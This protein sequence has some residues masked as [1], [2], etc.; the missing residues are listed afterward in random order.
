MTSG[1]RK[2]P[3]RGRSREVLIAVAADLFAR[4]P[5]DEIY[6]S[7]IAREAGV[8]NGLLSYHFNGKRGLYLAVLAEALEEINALLLPR[9]GEITKEQRLRGMVR[10]QIVYRR[11]HAHTML[12]L[13]RAGGQDPEVDEL[14]ERGRRAGT[15]CFLDLLDV[16]VEPT[17]TL[18]VAVRG[19]M[20]LLDEATRDW[21]VHDA[22]MGIGDLEE[23]VYNGAVAVLATVRS[24][25]PTIGAAVD[26]LTAPA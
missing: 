7:D 20:G 13:F 17:P 4:K 19:L 21:L 11:D 24:A 1:K 8:A 6:I 3:E 16:R 15:E 12:A 22:D 5:Y 9:D 23:V 18:R 26:E 2:A 14:F 10:R 25:H